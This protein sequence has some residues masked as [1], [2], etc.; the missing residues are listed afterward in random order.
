MLQVTGAKMRNNLNTVLLLVAILTLSQLLIAQQAP[1][2]PRLTSAK[3][4]AVVNDG[5]WAKA[6]RKFHKALRKWGRFHLIENKEQADIVIILSNQPG[7]LSAYQIRITDAKN[8]T[9]LWSDFGGPAK[10]LLS[11]SPVKLVKHLRKRFIGVPYTKPP[12]SD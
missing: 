6:Y 9:L 12:A 10:F 11:N 5:T 4:A 8:G 1:L 7:T 2:P 3:T